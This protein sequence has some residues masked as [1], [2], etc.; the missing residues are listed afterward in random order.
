MADNHYEEKLTR[1]DPDEAAQGKE[2]Y[3][4]N[5]KFLQKIANYGKRI[6][7]KTVYYALLLYYAFQSPDTPRSAKLTIAGA[8]GYLILPVDVIPDFIPV[9]GFADDAA[10]IISAIYKVISHI[11]ESMKRK[12]AERVR[13]IFGDFTG[14]EVDGEL[15]AEQEINK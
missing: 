1:L 12:A 14:E 8:L 11:D 15:V 7:T 10:V 5:Q 13:K 9:V 3:F 2:K 4:T 6:G